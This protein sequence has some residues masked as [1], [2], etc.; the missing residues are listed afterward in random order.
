MFWPRVARALLWLGGWTSVG[1]P[2]GVHKAVLIA[3]PHTS[4]W[5][6]FWALVYKVAVGLEV[7]L[8]VKDSLFWFPLNLLLR[9]LGAIPL[10]RGDAR[11]A[12]EQAIEA[13]NNEES[14]F[15]GL[16]PEGT[17]GKTAGWKTGFYR[18][19]EGA[20]VPVI[21]GFLDYRNKRLGLGPMVTLTGDMSADF[22]IIRSFYAAVEGRRP[23][24]T[25]PVTQLRGKKGTG[26]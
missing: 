12:V 15:F 13:F 17:R 20:G 26:K 1:G 23:D 19:A 22:K 7:K 8:F 4:N 18:I 5:D 14:F 6:G 9:G 25:S 21:L 3:A 24:Q 10:N 2:P 11:M 16:A